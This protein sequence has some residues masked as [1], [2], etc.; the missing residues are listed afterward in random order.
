VIEWWLRLL[1]AVGCARWS[2]ESMVDVLVH[3]MDGEGMRALAREVAIGEEK[4][5][6]SWMI[7]V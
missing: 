1:E 3:A 7:E 2:S 4:M 5:T 6:D